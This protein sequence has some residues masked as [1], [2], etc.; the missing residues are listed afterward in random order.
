[1]GYKEFDLGAMAQAILTVEGA[2]VM[3]SMGQLLVAVNNRK[4]GGLR[5]RFL[6]VD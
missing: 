6:G 3:G 4:I 5:A 2:I 1:M